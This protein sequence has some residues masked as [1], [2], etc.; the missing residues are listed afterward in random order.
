MSNRRRG[1]QYRLLWTWC[2]VLLAGVMWRAA[3]PQFA[4]GIVDLVVF[5]PP[6]AALGVAAVWSAHVFVP[7]RFSWHRGLV[8]AVVGGVVVS[9]LIAFLVGFSAMWDRASFPIV[10]I[11]GALLAIAGGLVAGLAGWIVS[12][13]RQ[14][15]FQRRLEEARHVHQ[16][17]GDRR[18]ARRR[19]LHT[20]RHEDTGERLP[21]GGLPSGR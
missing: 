18:G 2:A 16:A 9:P 7:E 4:G 14:W 12:W 20:G 5:I 10:F 1:V 17:I 6:G 11:V 8:G 19:R 13:I 15:W 3:T 21:A